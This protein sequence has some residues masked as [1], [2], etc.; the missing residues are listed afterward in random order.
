M[1]KRYKKDDEYIRDGSTKKLMKKGVYKLEDKG[2]KRLKVKHYSFYSALK[3]IS[4]LSF[5]LWW[6]PT[7][8]QMIA[9]YVGGRRAPSP[10]KAVVAAM[11]PVSVISLIVYASDNGILTAQISAFYTLPSSIA[12]GLA[13]TLPFTAP[14]IMFVANYMS[15]MIDLLNGTLAI[16]LNGFL[17]T[18]I[19]A[20]IG[21]ISSKN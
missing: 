6:L 8:G 14:Y 5:L 10:L 19:F 15:A 18:I 9:G 11:I 7:I 20:Y 13:E 12:M 21:G 1:L 3:S 2:R 17:V 16:W 4:L